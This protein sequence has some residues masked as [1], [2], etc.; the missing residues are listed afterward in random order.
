MLRNMLMQKLLLSIQ[1]KESPN[2]KQ[3]NSMP[4]YTKCD[5]H[6][7]ERAVENTSAAK[8]TYQHVCQVHPALKQD[9]A[10]KRLIE[11]ITDIDH[12]QEIHWPEADHLRYVLMIHELIRGHEMRPNH[13]DES[14]V[15]FGLE[16]L[17]N[18]YY[19]LSQTIKANQIIQEEGKNFSLGQ[20]SC[21]A[22]ETANNDTIKQAQKQGYGLVV[23]KDPSQGYIRIKVRP[24]SDIILKPLYEKI[25]EIDNQ[26]SWYY[27]PAGKM[28]LNGSQ[29]KQDMQPSPLSLEKIIELITNIYD[30]S[31][32]KQKAK[33]K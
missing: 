22:I 17:H 29:K 32:K 33:N 21:L 16:C 4:L 7:P 12:F 10:L 6:Q 26:G 8:L 2:S 23:I 15:H 9:Q 14:Q 5:H 27:H 28:L 30:K 24:D 25:N 11:F 31:S 19:A 3:Q 18:A 20:T 1:V 13:N